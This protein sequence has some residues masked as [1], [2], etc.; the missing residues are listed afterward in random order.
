LVASSGALYVGGHF[1]GM[2]GIARGHLAAMSPASGSLLVWNPNANG[3]LGVFGAALGGGHVAVGGEFTTVGGADH[4]G[5]A[6]FS[7]TP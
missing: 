4:Q 7:G 3:I 1:T 5:L 2:V 6:Q